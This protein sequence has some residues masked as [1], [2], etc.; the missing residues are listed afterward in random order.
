MSGARIA[1]RVLSVVGQLLL[2]WV[3]ARLIV[4][5]VSAPTRARLAG[6][7]AKGT[8]GA[9]GIGVVTHGAAPEG[10][11]P[12]L[13]VANH[14]SWL[15]VYAINAQLATRFVEKAETARWPLAGCITRAFGAIF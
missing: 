15:D 13:V 7:L 2:Q 5:F 12:F 14:V 8:L 3:A 10:A 1:A 9:C 11:E 6:G 4:P